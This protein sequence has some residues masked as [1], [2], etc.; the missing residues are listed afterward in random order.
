MASVKGNTA[1]FRAGKFV[2]GGTVITVGDEE[3]Q[4]FLDRG[5]TVVEGGDVPEVLGVVIPNEVSEEVQPL[6]PD[7]DPLANV[8]LNSAKDDE[9]K[10]ISSPPEEEA[11]KMRGRRKSTS[12]EG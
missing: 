1:I 11:P 5:F 6:I 8:K 7:G 9:P 12:T 10:V 3:L 2:P 4:D